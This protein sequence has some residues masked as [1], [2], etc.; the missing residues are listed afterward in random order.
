LRFNLL[1]RGKSL[2]FFSYDL[3]KV[4]K[5]CHFILL[6]VIVN[7]EKALKQGWNSQKLY[8]QTY[9]VLLS[10]MLKFLIAK[11]TRGRIFAEAS[12]V[13]QDINIYNAFFHLIRRGIS[14][15]SITHKEA[16]KHFTS[17]CFVTKINNDPEE[18]LADFF[19]VYGRL[20]M[21]LKLGKRKRQ[22]FNS[23]EK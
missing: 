4:F 17:L 14:T 7:K 13:S 1:K 15:I 8:R 16:K 18:Q 19:G 9:M 10:N 3:E 23:F 22:D 6:Y 11:K 5:K 2:K 21:D 20:K 12:N